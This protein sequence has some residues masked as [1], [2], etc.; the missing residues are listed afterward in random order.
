MLDFD[1]ADDGPLPPELSAA[2]R[3][4]HEPPETPRDAIWRAVE[5]GRRGAPSAA[6]AARLR[7]RGRLAAWSAA[8]AAVLAVGVG[9]GRWSA[10][11]P[12][13]PPAADAPAG[14]PAPA[15]APGR[16]GESAAYRVAAAEHLAQAEAFLTLFRASVREGREDRLAAGTARSLLASNRLLI[17]SPAAGDARLR[18]LLEDLE[19][20]L[21][22][23]AQLSPEHTGEEA[24]FITD[25]L[26]RGGVLP[27]LRAAVP[28][29]EPV[30]LRRGVL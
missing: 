7:S 18:L 2:A 17:D 20:V 3:A 26:D 21:A 11:G 19:L 13:A 23:I 14:A 27:R 1:P 28:A 5:A 16:S 10:R 9:L 25:G 12:A 6:S 8:A 30:F 4:Y 15:P 22:Q 29:G 24:H